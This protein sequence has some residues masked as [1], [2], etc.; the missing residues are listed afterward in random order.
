MPATEARIGY[1]TGF[2]LATPEAPAVYTEIAEIL[3]ITPPS[4]SRDLPEAT[5]MKSPDRWKEYIPG[6]RDG[7]EI[8]ME[9]NFVP[10]S[11]TTQRL[12]EA[13]GELSTSKAKVIFPDATEWGF[14]CFC[15]EFTPQVPVDDR[16][17]ATCTFKVTGPI[18]T[19][20][21]S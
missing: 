10:D 1:G 17:T 12:L 16:M 8:T 4:V 20:D 9:L 5:H 11:E 15:T 19:T 18:D 13:G 3:S 2:F 7:G 6:L 14:S 21:P